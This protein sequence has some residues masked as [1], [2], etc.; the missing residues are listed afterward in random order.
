[1]PFSA[2][3]FIMGS[4]MPMVLRLAMLLPARTKKAGL[5]GVGVEGCL[6]LPRC[7]EPWSWPCCDMAWEMVRQLMTQLAN[8][9]P[10]RDK[11]HCYM[12]N[13]TTSF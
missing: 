13:T 4:R 2:A 12:P 11:F 6:C 5:G 9:F 10:H 7:F 8:D 1:M 3:L